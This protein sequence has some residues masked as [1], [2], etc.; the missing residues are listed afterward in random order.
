MPGKKGNKMPKLSSAVFVIF[1][2]LVSGCGTIGPMQRYGYGPVGV[3]SLDAII[4][5]HI[6]DGEKSLKF[7]QSAE[8]FTK[9]KNEFV[10]VGQP[11]VLAITDST[12]YFLRW[13]SLH[14]QYE[15]LYCKYGKGNSNYSGKYS[16]II[17]GKSFIVFLALSI[18]G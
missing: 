1:C 16:S 6:G 18:L 12:V 10:T 7:R 2:L 8:M 15:I 3:P 14:F 9:E 5:H 13:N 11:G 4:L 17:C